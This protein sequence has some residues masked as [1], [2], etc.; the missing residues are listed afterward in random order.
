MPTA[1]IPSISPRETYLRFITALIEG[2]WGEAQDCVA[3]NFRGTI[4]SAPEDKKLTFGDYIEEIK[5]L[6][7]AYEYFGRTC[8]K[9]DIAVKD[10]VLTTSYELDMVF[11]HALKPRRG[12]RATSPL[13]SNN[14]PVRIPTV[15]VVTFNAAGEILTLVSTSDA[16]KTWGQMT[17]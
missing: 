9:S 12:S 3:S 6:R 8:G 15:D 2:K 13:P 4:S 17:A 11:A 10:G 16:A 1:Q 14:K 5:R 7:A